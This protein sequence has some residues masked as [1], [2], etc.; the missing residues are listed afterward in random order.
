MTFTD[1]PLNDLEK[2]HCDG[3]INFCKEKGISVPESYLTSENMLVRYLQATK[4][5]YQKTFDAVLM[6]NEWTIQTR[7]HICPNKQLAVDMLTKNGFI[8]FFRRDKFLRPIVV[9]NIA[10][11]K[12]LSADDLE[13]F[14]PT[15]SYLMTYSIQ[16]AL[17]PGKAECFVN[18]I[19]LNGVSMTS[20]PVTAI[21]RFLQSSQTNFRGR[22]YKTFILN[23]NMII[24]G[25]FGIVKSM[26][27]EFSA[28][29]INMLGSDFR[30]HLLEIIE[31]HNLEKRFGGTVPDKTGGFFP[32]DFSE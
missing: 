31:P 19:D 1:M 32:P 5:D 23:A 10:K 29:K 12:T 17:I 4:W 30:K 2:K 24:R 16:K 14:V 11:L 25:S 21:K 28:Q 8:Y 27:D 20:I 3:F 13:S 26:I 9:V 7:P 18:I 15:I 6:H 22:T